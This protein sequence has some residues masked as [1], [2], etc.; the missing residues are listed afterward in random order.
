MDKDT[1]IYTYREGNRSDHCACR[2]ILQIKQASRLKASVV[3]IWRRASLAMSCQ[4][5]IFERIDWHGGPEG[6][7]NTVKANNFYKQMFNFGINGRTYDGVWIDKGHH[8]NVYAVGDL[9]F[10]AKIQLASKNANC[11]EL[12]ALKAISELFPSHIPDFNPNL[13]RVHFNES[14]LS[15]L[16]MELVP[17]TGDEY[18]KCLLQ[19]KA[20]SERRERLVSMMSDLVELI[21][22]LVNVHDYW[23]QDIALCNIGFRSLSD[24]TAIVVDLDRFMP[25]PVGGKLKVRDMKKMLIIPYQVAQM[26]LANEADCHETWRKYNW[27][28]LKGHFDHCHKPDLTMFR[29]WC[30]R[31]FQI[32]RSQPSSSVPRTVKTMLP[33]PKFIAG[34]S[35]GGN[36]T[37]AVN[38]PESEVVSLRPA[39][40]SSPYFTQAQPIPSSVQYSNRSWPID[41]GHGAGQS[42]RNWPIDRGHDS[43]C[44]EQGRWIH[45]R[46]GN[47]EM[48]KRSPAIMSSKQAPAG[49]DTHGK[50][51]RDAYVL[52]L[53]IALVLLN[54]IEDYIGEDVIRE[55]KIHRLQNFNNFR[56]HGML[57]RIYAQILKL[58]GHYSL[59][60]TWYE[61]VNAY[62][63]KQIIEAEMAILCTQQHATH[64][65]WG[66]SCKYMTSLD[67]EAREKIL[68][69]VLRHWPSYRLDAVTQ[70][71]DASAQLGLSDGPVG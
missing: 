69:D 24:D 30:R 9:N 52:V 25:V 60:F 20:T 47:N 29:A 45:Y 35:M 27:F 5:A 8:R 23:P 55:H 43:A 16:L 57:P 66:D 4:R 1:Y 61:W 49:E 2:S 36:S 54:A 11:S 50:I 21:H 31:L 13:F 40:R 22:A 7:K 68:Q 28:Q 38:L 26:V 14:D 32:Q 56:K 59:H 3:L 46:D 62:V 71:N 6:Y 51:P 65:Q 70:I 19:Q 67:D 42:S 10:V 53:N 18:V 33:Q 34:P 15:V 37:P 64:R 12:A 39:Q 48:Q 17:H 44:V 58:S 63:V 41:R